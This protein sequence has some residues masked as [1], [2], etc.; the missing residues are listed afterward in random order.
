MRLSFGLTWIAVAWGACL[1]ETAWAQR[2]YSGKVVY[3]MFGPRVL[4]ETLQSPVQRVERGI[5]R[6]AYGDFVGINRSYSGL[7]FPGAKPRPPAVE[8]EPMPWEPEAQPEIQPAPD[9]WLR[10]RGSGA[11]IIPSPRSIDVDLPDSSSL[12]GPSRTPALAGGTAV[13]VGFPSRAP[14]SDPFAR[15]IAAVLERTTRIHK[16]SP[17]R[18]VVVHETAILRGRVATRQDRELAENIVRFEPGVWDVKN[19]LV[20]E[21]SPRVATADARPGGS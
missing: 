21:D 4:G 8:P 11:D 6:D 16:V 10:T 2:D 12:R 3:G 1:A 14:A 7:R 18:V 19:E 5:A 17:I 13:M 9:E 15:R 20:V